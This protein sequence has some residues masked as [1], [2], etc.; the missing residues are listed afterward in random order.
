MS[1]VFTN[2]KALFKEL[3]R[4]GY[5]VNELCWR[6]PVSQYHRKMISPKYCDLTNSAGK[7]D[8][9]AG[10]AAAFLQAFVEEGV[11]WAHIDIAGTGLVGGEAGGWGSRILV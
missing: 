6:M 3:D 9:G 7:S 5:H 2:D 4:A 8:A 1:G 11:R 10:Q